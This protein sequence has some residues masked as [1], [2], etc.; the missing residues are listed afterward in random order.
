MQQIA[1]RFKTLNTQGHCKNQTGFALMEVFLAV[2]VIVLSAVGS[3][4]LYNY[5]LKQQK[6]SRTSNQIISMV[7]VY[8]NLYSSHLTGNIKTESDLIS[9]FYA[10]G[11]LSENFFILSNGSAT[12]MT[13]AYGALSF[14][15]ISSTQFNVIVPVSANTDGA[16]NQICDAVKNYVKNCTKNNNSSVTIM[17]QV[18]DY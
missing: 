17:I 1:K 8:S 2:I 14:N 7:S 16:K 10:S 11:R 3:Y 5:V 4:Y 6:N 9:T 13:S 18:G 15:N 12:A